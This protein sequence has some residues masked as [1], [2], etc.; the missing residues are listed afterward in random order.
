LPDYPSGQLRASARDLAAL[1]A[2]LAAAAPADAGNDEQA[3]VWSRPPHASS[4]RTCTPM[5]GRPRQDAPLGPRGTT[6][7]AH[8]VLLL[9]LAALPCDRGG[10][11]A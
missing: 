11:G 7:G 1:F 3:L 2:M 9:T 8:D 10:L 6:S 4:S 5:A